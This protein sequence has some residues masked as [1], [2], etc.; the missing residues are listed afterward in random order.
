MAARQEEEEDLGCV[1]CDCLSGP[2][3]LAA[4]PFQRRLLKLLNLRRLP[5]GQFLDVFENRLMP[6][7]ANLYQLHERDSTRVEGRLKSQ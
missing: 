6:R 7:R 4:G 2:L 1:P 3:T 5:V